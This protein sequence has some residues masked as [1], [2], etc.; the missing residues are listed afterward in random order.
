MAGYFY[1]EG[2][3]HPV[4]GPSEIASAVDRGPILL[5]TGPI[6]RRWVLANA[7]FATQVLAEGPR[8]NALLRVEKR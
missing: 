3:V 4:A 5:L 8:G 7:A 2:R 1:N 6:E